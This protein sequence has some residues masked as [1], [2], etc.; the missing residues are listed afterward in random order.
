MSKPITDEWLIGMVDACEARQLSY[1]RGLCQE[2]DS[3]YLPFYRVTVGAGA[4]F[5]CHLFINPDCDLQRL[6][7]VQSFAYR[8]RALG[9]AMLA[10]LANYE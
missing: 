8:P 7:R 2:C 6:D 10:R 4:T 1:Q 3:I 5:G 9:E